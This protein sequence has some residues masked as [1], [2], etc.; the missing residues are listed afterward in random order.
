M[1]TMNSAMKTYIFIL[2]ILLLPFTGCKK[3]L[4]DKPDKTLVVPATI[5]DYQAL[6]DNASIM[7]MQGPSIGEV[8]SDNYYMTDAAYDALPADRNRQA[9]IW[10]TGIFDGQ[11]P[12]DWSNAYDIVNK[13]NIVLNNIDQVTYTT[14]EQSSWNNVKGSALF[15]RAKAF[16]EAIAIWGKQ[17]DSVS[18]ITDPGIPLRLSADFN[19]P[20][21]RSTVSASYHQIIQ[22]LLQAIPLL[23]VQ[24][25][26]VM[27][28]SKRTAYAMTARI[29][30]SMRKYDK[31]GYYAD[32]C[33]NLFHTLI[34]Y[35]TLSTGA[36]YPFSQFNAETIFYSSA[37]TPTDLNIKWAKI[38]SAL[39]QSYNQNDLRKVLFFKANTDGSV[40]FKGNYTGGSSFF[41]GISADELYLIRA[42]SY[43]RQGKTD[44]ALSDLNTLLRA[45]WKIGTFLPLM[46]TDAQTALNIIL[47]ERRKELLFRMLRWADIKRLNKEPT[48]QISL[49]RLVH[50]QLYQLSSDDSKYAL[51]IPTDIIQL[52][53]M[54]QN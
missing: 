25:L 22:D 41:T 32:S 8:S 3:F 26:Q 13:A 11:Y 14:A 45:R 6:L 18:S 15:F 43:A 16:Y 5:S 12:N 37:G 33:L 50:G 20:S 24:P 38:D 46:A 42:E 27:R 1:K 19:Q 47:T 7:N 44:L 48:F 17:Y 4:S 49:Q 52:T 54:Q 29:Y 28:P 36:S 51:P 2:L 31:A 39:Y 40:A 10:G 34:D 35:N 53:G 30:L 9:Y 23:P 21:I